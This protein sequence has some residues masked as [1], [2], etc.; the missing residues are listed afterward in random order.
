MIRHT[1]AWRAAMLG[2]AFALLFTAA[3]EKEGPAERAGKKMDDAVEDVGDKLED[4]G[5]KAEDA[6]D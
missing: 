3:C 4:V 5:D 1:R 2:A 6:V